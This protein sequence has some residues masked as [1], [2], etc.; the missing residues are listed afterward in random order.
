[1][2]TFLH[3]ADKMGNITLAVPEE[4]HRK[5]KKHSEIRWSE[6]I[7]KTISEKINDLEMMNKLSTKSNL[8]KKDIEEI[9]KKV[10]SRVAKKLGLK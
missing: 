7:R 3:I 9:S 2:I 6:V 10:D 5:M 4:L 1:M 8:T